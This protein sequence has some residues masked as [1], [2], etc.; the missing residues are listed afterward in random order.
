LVKEILV[1]SP[2]IEETKPLSLAINKISNTSIYKWIELENKII[3]LNSFDGLILTGHESTIETSATTI[4]IPDYVFAITKEALDLNLSILGVNIGMHVINIVL[5]G[6]YPKAINQNLKEN[7]GKRE[8]IFVSPGS[9]LTSIIGYGGLMRINKSNMFG[10]TVH[11]K[12]DL[13]RASAYSINGGFIEAFESDQ[14]DSVFGIQFDP[15]QPNIPP[16]F[17]NLLQSMLN[18]QKEYIL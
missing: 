2:S 13:L 15:F 3:D 7:I 8:D 1:L 17:K 10:I 6:L 4:N 12:S 18:T 5:G 14:H 9:K 11:E 16:N